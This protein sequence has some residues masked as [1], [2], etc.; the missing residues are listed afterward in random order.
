MFNISQATK[1]L[2]NPLSSPMLAFLLLVF[3]MIACAGCDVFI[4]Q[5]LAGGYRVLAIDTVEMSMITGSRDS[6]V[7]GGVGP[8]VFA[9]GWNQNFIIAK[10]HPNESFNVDTNITNWF[11]IEVASREVHGPLTEKEYVELRKELGVPDAITFTE[12]IELENK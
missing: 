2:C 8:M 12:Q 11:I 4:D 3:G 1:K 6:D 7:K 5:D 9:Y 10:Q